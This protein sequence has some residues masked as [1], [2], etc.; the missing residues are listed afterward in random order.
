MPELS[1]LVQQSP[2]LRAASE[3]YPRFADLPAGST[4][5]E[6]NGFEVTTRELDGRLYAVRSYLDKFFVQADFAARLPALE[7]NRPGLE[8]L[9]ALSIEAGVLVTEHMF[10][11]N[12]EALSPEEAGSMS[13][14]QFEELTNLV[15][16]SVTNGIEID[17][18]ASNIFYDHDKGF[19]FVDCARPITEPSPLR[20]L[21]GIA[22]ALMWIG[23]DLKTFNSTE[24]IKVRENAIRMLTQSVFTNLPMEVGIDLSR[25]AA[26]RIAQCQSGNIYSTEED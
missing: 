2:I 15:D 25:S 19:G 12:I 6:C 14:A 4:I 22:Q 11:R 10:G 24:S 17:D 18:D 21:Q 7:N 1:M 3:A 5:A 23:H 16:W 9:A 13:L 26:E 8:K 20:T